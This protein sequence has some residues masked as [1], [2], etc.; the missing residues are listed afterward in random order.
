MLRRI[1][2]K[3]KNSN[4]K[5]ETQ[6]AVLPR[7]LWTFYFKYSVPGSWAPLLLYAFFS[8]AALSNQVLFPYCERWFIALFESPVP[9]G[10]NF[11]QFALPTILLI[12]GLNLM[13]SICSILRGMYQA[14]W[15]PQIRN[16]TSVVLNDYVHSQSMAFWT[17]RMAGQVNSQINYVAE[18]FWVIEEFWRIVGLLVTMLINVGLIFTINAYVAIIFAV[19]FVFR[20]AYSW[21]MIKPM[22]RTSKE[23]SSIFSKLSGKI[24]DSISNFSVV[25]L[26]AGAARER[27]HLEPVRN[28]HIAARIKSFFVQRLFW[29]VPSVVWDISYGATLLFCAYLYM[30]G[31]IT[32]SEIVFTVSI[33]F[34]TMGTI[35][36]IVSQIPIIT[37]RLGSASK[38]YAELV[39][40]ITVM[41]APNAPALHVT[42]GEIEFRNVSFRYKRKWVL[43]NF[44]LKI[45][46]G[47]RVGLVGPSGAGK[48]TLVNLLMRFYDPTHG[49]ILID[50]QNIRDV[51]QDSLRESIAFIPQEPAMFNR[52]LREN[53]GYGKVDATDKEVRT[54]AKRAMAHEFIMGTDKKYDSL[55]GDRGIKLSGGQRQRI[56]IA[57]AFL[58]DAP[59]L[60]LDEATSALDS[61]TEVAIQSSF[62]ELAE[63]RTTVAIA[64]R[65]STLRNMDRIVVLKDGHVIE[66]GSHKT[67]L[68]RGGEYARLWKMQSGGF[69]QD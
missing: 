63:G 39:V 17:G 56:A 50:G 20:A 27:N 55:V 1:I 9:A 51:S 38:A 12:V 53:I 34:S 45:K 65:L 61:E 16:R 4:K 2:G 67:L 43:R 22:N 68:R 24:V 23:S 59:I 13:I 60:V 7:S 26:F 21:A 29:G 28:K 37:E 62:D 15:V 49:E 47:E 19:V 8:M 44:N 42:C 54:A 5:S 30:H 66:T 25:K 69:L 35:S 41:D 32:V 18:G 48:T 64:H 57:R 3:S 14:R 11:V 52:T 33:Y 36:A 31:Q 46:C 6:N 40:P 58:K 10:M